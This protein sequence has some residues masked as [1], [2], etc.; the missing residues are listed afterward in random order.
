MSELRIGK[1]KEELYGGQPLGFGK[2]KTGQQWLAE[3]RKDLASIVEALDVWQQIAA[4]ISCEAM[5]CN[6]SPGSSLTVPLWFQNLT[7][8][9]ALWSDVEL[10]IDAAPICEFRRKM[11]DLVP[12]SRLMP[13]KVG[14]CRGT[15]TDLEIE[16]CLS[17]ARE[18]FDRVFRATLARASEKQQTPATAN[19]ARDKWFH[20]PSEPR[21]PEYKHGPITGQKKEICTWMGEKPGPN[22][23]RLNQKANRTAWV[24]RHS[25]TSWEVWFK[26][27]RTFQ[28]ADSNRRFGLKST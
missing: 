28:S 7:S 25:E 15:M 9:I 22:M 5:S 10:H 24:I 3:F 12:R 16:T 1:T 19:D 17:T 2:S 6:S 14:T 11:L 4:D 20:D 27:E 23:R 21:P 26:D 18:T 13:G 8:I